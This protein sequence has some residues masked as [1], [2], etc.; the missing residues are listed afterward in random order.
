[1][2]GD[3]I[4]IRLSTVAILIGVESKIGIALGYGIAYIP[5]VNRIRR[6]EGSKNV[7]VV[8]VVL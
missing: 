8:V 7:T 6:P 3:L 5:G 1:V 4:L 2:G